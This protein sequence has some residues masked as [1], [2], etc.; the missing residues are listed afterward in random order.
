[1]EKQKKITL[2]KK[3]VVALIQ[4]YGNKEHERFKEI[5]FDIAKEF[6]NIGD[7]ELSEYIMAQVGHS[8][9]EVNDMKGDE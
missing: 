1:M 2:E 3:Q 5:V 6:D 4:S 9:W 8:A 7:Y